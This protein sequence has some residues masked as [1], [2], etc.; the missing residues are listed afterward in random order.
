MAKTTEN[1]IPVKCEIWDTEYAI[2]NNKNGSATIS[3]PYAKWKGNSAS[4]AFSKHVL[5]D[6]KAV[7]LVNMMIDSGRSTLLSACGM[8][9]LGIEDL[10][11]H[12]YMS[13]EQ[14]IK[15]KWETMGN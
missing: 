14:I 5:S 10:L 7:E 1:Y 2:K 4:L 12:G 6:K 9:F 11:G 13:L 15:T 3:V 8:Q